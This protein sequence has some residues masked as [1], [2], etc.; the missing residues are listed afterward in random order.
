MAYSLL[1]AFIHAGIATSDSC[2]KR[3]PGRVE[4]SYYYYWFVLGE[5]RRGLILCMYIAKCL[6]GQ[7]S[8]DRFEQVA[9]P[10]RLL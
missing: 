4:N 6:Q 5:K 8:Y 9:T 3:L 2:T 10:N 1:C 7:G